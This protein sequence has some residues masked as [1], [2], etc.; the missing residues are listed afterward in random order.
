M[1]TV[2]AEIPDRARALAELRR[3]LKP[4]GT[5]SVSEL[6]LDPDCPRRQT[7]IRW[8]EAA[9]FRLTSAY[10][11]LLEHTASFASDW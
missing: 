1:V 8:C 5:L 3:V 11:G 10:G 2:L 7:E 9:G 4:G 6:L